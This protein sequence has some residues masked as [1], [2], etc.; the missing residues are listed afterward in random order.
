MPA[1]SPHPW[2]DHLDFI[3]DHLSLA[4][5]WLADIAYTEP[6]DHPVRALHTDLRYL[7][8][9]LHAYSAH[10]PI[11]ERPAPCPPSLSSSSS[12]QLPLWAASSEASSPTSSPD[13]SIAA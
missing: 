4:E 2:S 3:L 1:P 7:M 11:P 5:Q 6:R 12:S 8:R 9:R 10:A 13:A